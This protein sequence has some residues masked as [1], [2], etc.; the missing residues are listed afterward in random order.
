MTS[1]NTADICDENSAV[2]IAEPI[3]RSFGGIK[4]DN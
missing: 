4:N 2:E 1:F 3:F